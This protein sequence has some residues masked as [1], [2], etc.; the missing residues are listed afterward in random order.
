[1]SEQPL[2]TL[3]PQTDFV[4]SQISGRVIPISDP[5]CRALK[6]L[7]TWVCFTGPSPEAITPSIPMSQDR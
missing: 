4:A 1:M 6:V 7:E 5:A 2:L 3:Q